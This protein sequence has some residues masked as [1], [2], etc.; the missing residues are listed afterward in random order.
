MIKIGTFSRISQVSV[1][2]LRYYDEI[3]LLK[4]VEVDRFTGYRYYSF[5]QLARLN[6]ILMLKDLGFSLEQI[7]RLLDE[8]LS[9][10]EMRGML[11]MKQ[12]ELRDKVQDELSKLERVEARLRLIEQ[13]AGM[14]DYDVIIKKVEPILVAGLREIIPTYPEQGPLWDRLETCLAQQG[15]VPSGPCFTIYYSDEPEI[16]AEVCEPLSA[17][18]PPAEPIMVHQL[19][20]LEQMASLVHKGPFTSLVEAYSALIQWIESNGYRISDPGREIYLE[21]PSIP[22][23]QNDPNTVTEIQF[24]VEKA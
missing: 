9:S 23:D 5:E 15:A 22:G 2:T 20:A 8:D 7:T 21:V 1:K 18:V 12:A 6:R 3:G 17:P 19:P 10:S 11:R 4:P 14:S 13:E 24:P 16:D